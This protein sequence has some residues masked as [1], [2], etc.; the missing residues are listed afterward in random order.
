MVVVWIF[1]CEVVITTM[2]EATSLAKKMWLSTRKI[3]EECDLDLI[4]DLTN[5]DRIKIKLEDIT[6]ACIGVL[7]R[8]NKFERYTKIRWKNS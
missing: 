8:L 3:I 4:E 7:W 1:E 2:D 5:D 6:S